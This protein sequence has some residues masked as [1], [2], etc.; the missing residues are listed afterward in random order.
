MI[1]EYK[2]RISESRAGNLEPVGGEEKEINVRHR[3]R[4]NGRV[5]AFKRLYPPTPQ[6]EKSHGCG[7]RA[8]SR[9]VW[10]GGYTLNLSELWQGRAQRA[11]IT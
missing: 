8:I 5:K 11:D 10:A 4:N 1:F 7:E 6:K 3:K 9:E 2:Y